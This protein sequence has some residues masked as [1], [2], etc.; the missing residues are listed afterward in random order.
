MSSSARI[1]TMRSSERIFTMRPSARIS[2]LRQKARISVIISNS[3]MAKSCER[4]DSVN[5]ERKHVLSL[6]QRQFILNEKNKR[7]GKLIFFFVSQTK[8][9][10]ELGLIKT[11]ISVF[12]FNFC[13]M[14]YRKFQCS[15]F[16]RLSK[17]VYI[18]C[19]AYLIE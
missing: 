14:I 13:S 2:T 10:S 4:R 8:V 6:P 11:H 15:N 7:T 5:F 18:F 9:E 17:S 12:L 3:K 19:Q 16:R 1:S